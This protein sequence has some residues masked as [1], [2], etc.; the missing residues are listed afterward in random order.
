MMALRD[1]I[2]EENMNKAL[3]S[4]IA[5]FKFSDAIQPTTLDLVAAIKAVSLQDDF[6]FIDDQFNQISIYDLKI[7][8][9]DVKKLEDEEYILTLNVSAKQFRASGEGEESEQAF[10]DAVEIV[11]FSGDPNDFSLK[12]EIVYREKHQLISGENSIIITTNKPFTYVGIDPFVRFIDR[13]SRDNVKK[14]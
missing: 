5:K 1:R 8:E 13:N 14:L 2:G 6:A 12:N 10:E 7:N 11:L 3:R 9:A 4:L